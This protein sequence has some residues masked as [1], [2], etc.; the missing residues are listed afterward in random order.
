MIMSK[1]SKRSLGYLLP[2]I[3]LGFLTVGATSLLTL[4]TIAAPL[5]DQSAP[6]GVHAANSQGTA[7]ETADASARSYASVSASASAYGSANGQSQGCTAQSSSHAQATVN[8]HTVEK[9]AQ[10]HASGPGNNC[11]ANS[12]SHVWVPGGKAE[13]TPT[14]PTVPKN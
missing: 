13:P 12:S 4:P 2:A 6:I 14:M 11:S 8:G 3:A 5:T 10:K 9:N 1:T 7:I